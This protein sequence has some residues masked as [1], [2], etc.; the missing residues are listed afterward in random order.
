[1]LWGT[2]IAGLR[3]ALELAHAGRVLVLAKSEALTSTRPQPDNPDL[4]SD[5]EEVILHLKD[6]LVAG[7]GLCDPEAVKLLIDEGTE[8]IEELIGW[9]KL[10]HKKTKL[11]FENEAA[12]SHSHVLHVPGDSAIHE[13]SRILQSKVRSTKNISVREFEF[14]TEILTEDQ[15]ATALGLIDDKGL[16]EEITC[17]AVLLATGALGQ[18]Y[19]NTTNS[20]AATGDGVAIAFRAGAEI[21]DMEFVQFHPA[22]LYMKKVPR[23]LLSDQLR[24]EG[25]YLR[26]IELDRFMSKYH[27][28][29]EKAPDDVVTRAIV[30]EMEVSGSRDPF[31]YLDLTHLNGPHVRQR[32]PRIYATCMSHNIDI[33]ED[34]IPVR[35]AAHFA[36][37]GVRTDIHGKTSV[38]GLYAGGETAAT[39]VHGANRFPSNSLLEALVFGTR[40]GMAMRNELKTSRAGT[41]REKKAA[42]QNGPVD[43]GVEDAIRQIQEV[44]WKHVGVVRSR[45]EMQ[46]ALKVLERLAQRLGH[47]RTRRSHEA[48]DLLTTALLVARSAL[49][50]EE[51]RGAHYRIDYPAH[52]DKKFLKHSVIKGNSVRFV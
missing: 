52:D 49:A 13:V 4:L 8:R 30:H 35:P 39:A 11:I 26:N 1:L 31:V 40:A 48:A 9:D 43:A 46:E 47:P 17:S 3:A 38:A 29:A 15:R 6:S 19:G 2:G 18:V 16:P 22:A 20:I 10:E 50:R 42:S 23:F 5:E 33:T 12:Y 41:T 27:Q 25:A 36:I 21:I 51:S 24:S 37:G 44:M 14:C 34:M 28:L 32:F 7:D 45:R